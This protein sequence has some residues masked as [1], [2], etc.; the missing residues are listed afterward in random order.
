VT[1]RFAEEACVYEMNS[2]SCRDGDELRSID[3]SVR[4]FD[5]VPDAGAAI[6]ITRAEMV[7]AGQATGGR[8]GPGPM[9]PAHCRVNGIVDKRTGADG[10]TYG[11]RFA[12]ALPDNWVVV[13]MES[14]GSRSVIRP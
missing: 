12:V 4:R 5:S 1:L 11:I 9:L 10:K 2:F 14:W 7:A 6:E 8:G 13:S 3:Q